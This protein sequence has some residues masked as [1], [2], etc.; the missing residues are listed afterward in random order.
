MLI[1]ESIS[2]ICLQFLCLLWIWSVS[3]IYVCNTTSWHLRNHHFT[4]N[5]ACVN[6]A[7]AVLKNSHK[8][9]I[10]MF[11]RSEQNVGINA[12]SASE[13]SLKKRPCKWWRLKVFFFY[14]FILITYWTTLVYQNDN[15]DEP[16]SK[17]PIVVTKI[18]FDIVARFG[19]GRNFEN[20][21]YNIIFG[22]MLNSTEC[23]TFL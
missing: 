17:N 10:Y 22:K 18:V 11:L 5:K 23:N 6:V 19:G 16:I 15:Y 4:S 14:N 8:P 12:L 2:S 1:G 3:L 7:K 20:S 13:V 9:D 21:T